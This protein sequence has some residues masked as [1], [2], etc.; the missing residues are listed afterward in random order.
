MEKKSLDEIE[1]GAVFG[2]VDEREAI[3]GLLGERSHR[4]LGF[5]G[6]VIVEDELD[7]GRGAD[8][9]GVEL[10]REFDEFTRAM[11]IPLDAGVD[12]RRSY[13]SMPASRLCVP[14]RTYS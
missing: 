5:V 3:F 10:F 13:R 8:G 7:R 4:L 1:A 12:R 2:S 6:G 9:R 14:N 11:S